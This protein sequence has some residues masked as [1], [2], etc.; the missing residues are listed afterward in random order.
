MNQNRNE[1]MQNQRPVVSLSVLCQALSIDV[2]A[3]VRALTHLGMW[4]HGKHWTVN[5][6]E[7]SITLD[8]IASNYCLLNMTG[9]YDDICRPLI[10]SM[11]KIYGDALLDEKA[12]MAIIHKF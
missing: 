4:Q 2:D 3:A 1:K 7:V 5:R 9:K 11:G 10:D 12:P 6:G 8:G